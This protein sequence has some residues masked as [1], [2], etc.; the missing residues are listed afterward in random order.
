VEAT[1]RVCEPEVTTVTFNGNSKVKRVRQASRRP[2][3]LAAS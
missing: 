2:P 3:V 1:N